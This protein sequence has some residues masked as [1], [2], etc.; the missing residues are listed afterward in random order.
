MIMWKYIK[1]ERSKAMK[2]RVISLFTVLL[3]ALSLF[4]TTVFADAYCLEASTDTAVCIE[5]TDWKGSGKIVFYPKTLESNDETYP[6]VVWANGT[7][8]VTSLYY[9]LLRSFAS[10][11]YIVVADTT[12]MSADGKDQISAIDYIAEKS[13]QPDSILYGRVNMEKICAA[14]HSQGGRS[15]INAAAA[16][17]RISCVLSIAGSS[18]K[19]EAKGVTCPA[20]FMTGTADLMVLSS[21]WVKPAYEAVQ[22]S[23]V[24]ASLKGGIHTTCIINHEKIS[25]YAIAWLDA[26]LKGSDEA[27]AVFAPNG[28]LANDKAWKSFACK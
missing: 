7:G 19:N 6:V 27:A 26:N 28:A 21:V 3:L 9:D 11:G 20:F 10:A 22:G 4:G 16:D 13:A 1:H 23:A 18:F 14:G 15:A 17:S 12:V 24:Y 25:G 5:D 2:K 8:C